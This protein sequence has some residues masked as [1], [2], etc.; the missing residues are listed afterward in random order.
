[1]DIILNL[2]KI[3]FS[4]VLGH[5]ILKNITKKIPTTD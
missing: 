5:L 1:M 4:L 2:N 3:F